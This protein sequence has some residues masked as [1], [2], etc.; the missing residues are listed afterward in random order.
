MLSELQRRRARNQQVGLLL[1]EEDLAAF[2]DS[3]ARLY[4][5]GSLN[6]PE[7]IASRLFAGLRTLEEAGVE[8]I[9]CR[10]F[11]ETGIGLAISDRLLKAASGRVII[12][13][14]YA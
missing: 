4:V 2:A 6:Q 8:V 10:G 1:A 9:L 11:D 13:P 3:G 7:H 14:D 5:L 12:L